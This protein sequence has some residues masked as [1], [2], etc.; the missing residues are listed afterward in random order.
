[1]CVAG[2]EGMLKTIRL[3]IIVEPVLFA[4]LA[5][6]ASGDLDDAS[7]PALNDFLF[8]KHNE[9]DSWDETPDNL[10]VSRIFCESFPKTNEFLATNRS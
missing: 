4:G 6:L 7:A 8:L 9:P 10:T 2:P 5:S 1:M 3:I